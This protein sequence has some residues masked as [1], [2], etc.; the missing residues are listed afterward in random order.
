MSEPKKMGRPES[1]TDEMLDRIIQAARCGLTDAQIAMVWGITEQTLNN[2]KVRYPDFFESL[3]QAKIDWDMEIVNSLAHRAK[4]YSHKE[5]KH[6]VIKNKIVEKEVDK[7]YPPDPDATSAIFWLKN[8]LPDQFRE[9]QEVEHV[10]E[11][12]VINYNADKGDVETF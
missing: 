2:Y 7:H 10:G 11:A 6:F 3:K 4:G 9:K 8:R 1:L 12:V 5:T